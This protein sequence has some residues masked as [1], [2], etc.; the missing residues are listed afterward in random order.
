MA[1]GTRRSLPPPVYSDV[2]KGRP[3]MECYLCKQTQAIYTHPIKWKNQTLLSLLK[4]LEP[5]LDISPDT[6][7]CR[8]CHDSLCSGQ[9]TENFQPRWTRL[10]SCSSKICEVATRMYQACMQEYKIGN[11][12]RY[13]R[14]FELFAL[15]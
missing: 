12:W 15:E 7:I 6:C 11:T 9:G 2:H 13:W 10:A 8:N 1:T 5:D 3:C 14:Y 4:D